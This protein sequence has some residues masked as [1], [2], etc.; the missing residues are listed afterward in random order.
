MPTEQ[1]PIG[2]FDPAATA[3][4]VLRGVDLTGRIAL[5]TGG[6]SGIGLETTRA[7]H[8]AGAKVIVPARDPGKAAAALAGLEGVEIEAMDLLDPA[9][10]DA[11]A[12]GFLV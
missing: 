12:A 6:S 3:A 11:F 9:S 10:I 4:D 5:V 1:R 8:A 7:L 2:S